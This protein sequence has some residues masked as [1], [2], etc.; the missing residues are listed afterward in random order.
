MK[1]T[2][3]E[4]NIQTGETTFTERDETPAELKAREAFEKQ[5]I[6]EQ[7]E[8]EKKANAKAALLEKLGITAEEA[9]LLLS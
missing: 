9:K 6:K 1:I 5:V 2:E 3:K 4:F 7:T 8:A